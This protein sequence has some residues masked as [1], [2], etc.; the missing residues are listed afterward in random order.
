MLWRLLVYRC[1]ATGTEILEYADLQNQIA[2]GYLILYL[3]INGYQYKLRFS[4]SAFIFKLSCTKT[5]I[6]FSSSPVQQE[7]IGRYLHYVL[8]LPSIGKED[9]VCKNT[10]DK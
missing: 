9:D 1:K 6:V 8:T 3:Q 2:E 7:D 10:K 5:F 4:D